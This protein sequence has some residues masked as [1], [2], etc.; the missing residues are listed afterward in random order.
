RHVRTRGR[1]SWK[2]SPVERRL[3]L[4]VIP[5]RL[6]PLTLSAR[7][8]REELRGRA[9]ISS[10]VR[11]HV[12]RCIFS[13]ASKTRLRDTI[14]PCPCPS[15]LLDSARLQSRIAAQLQNDVGRGRQGRRSRRAGSSTHRGCGRRRP[16]APRCVCS[17]TTECV[18]TGRGL[19]VLTRETS[20]EEG[21]G[22]GV[23]RSGCSVSSIVSCYR[24][25]F[26]LPHRIFLFAPTSLP[27]RRMPEGGKE[28]RAVERG[29]CQGHVASTPSPRS[30][31]PPGLELT[32][33]E[34]RRDA[35]RLVS[36]TRTTRASHLHLRWAAELEASRRGVRRYDRLCGGRVHTCRGRSDTDRYLA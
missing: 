6:P 17:S 15:R 35:F 22:G 36:R 28:T 14:L 29:A 33:G 11:V 26:S 23:R 13:I 9:S 12:S 20:A 2:E 1:K 34:S 8:W 10:S 24:H 27:C 4:G 18:R 32:C 30:R 31:A 19:C 16:V 5:A 25:R 21:D 3:S 7:A